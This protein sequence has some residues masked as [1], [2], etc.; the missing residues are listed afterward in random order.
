MGG[1]TWVVPTAVV[2]A[3]LCRL[4]FLGLAAGQDEA[5]FLLVAK[6]WGGGGTSLY[7]DYWVD[8]PPLLLSIFR[9]GSMFGGLPALRLIGCLAVALTVLGSALAAGQ[10][11][12]RAASRWAAVTAAALTVTPLLGGLEI[13]GELLASP[14]IVFGIAAVVTALRSTDERR[15]MTMAALAGAAGAGAMLVKQNLADVAVFAVVAYAVAWRRHE[16]PVHRL[17]GLVLCSLAGGLTVVVLMAAQAQAHGTSLSGLL[18]A[19]YPFRVQA[20]Q[21]MAASGSFQALGRLQNLLGGVAGSGLGLL[22]IAIASRA[23]RDRQGSV[24]CWW[25]LLATIVF[26]IVSV[27]SGGNYWMHYL[28][29]LVGPCAIAVGVLAARK[30]QVLV[31]A[32]VA[33]PIASAA[34]VWAVSLTLPQG[35]VGTT[36]GAAIGSAAHPNDTMVTAYGHPEVDESSGLSSP[37]PYLWSLPVKTLD[38]QLTDLDRVL[39]GLARPTWLVVWSDIS[40]WGLTTGATDVAVARHYH[41][42]AVLCGRTV[43]LRNG[44]D[45]PTP[46]VS[47]CPPGFHLESLKTPWS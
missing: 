33:F 41:L 11:G 3:V 42:V 38:P 9:L 4:P 1:G 29:E 43:Y 18:Y 31:R 6:H 26:G 10:L 39:A 28:L 35:S 5:G 24:C 34:V 8:R 13:N 15:A 16:Q 32:A 21:V 22:L 37:Y 45:R 19:M 30:Q 7:G 47:E 40:S 20:G 12:G 44:I 14:F 23:R 25:A 27:L 36:V 2:V 17:G 46:V